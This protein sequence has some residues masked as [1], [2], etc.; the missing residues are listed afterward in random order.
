MTTSDTGTYPYFTQ[1]PNQRDSIHTYEPKNTK[2]L[3]NFPVNYND[4]ITSI[5]NFLHKCKR[6][7]EVLR[8]ERMPLETPL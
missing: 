1:L 7:I 6:C 5:P 3:Q 4:N 8:T 2:F